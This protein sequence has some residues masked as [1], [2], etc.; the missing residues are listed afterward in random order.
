MVAL[1]F[2]AGSA[3]VEIRTVLEGDPAMRRDK[4][5]QFKMSA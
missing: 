1:G 2:G 4:D 3:N 5:A